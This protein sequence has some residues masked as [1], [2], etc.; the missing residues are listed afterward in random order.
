MVDVAVDHVACD[1]DAVAVVA[2]ARLFIFRGSF[3]FISVVI[4]A[5][6]VVVNAVATDD[7]VIARL[8]IFRGNCWYF[9]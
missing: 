2:V 3:P 7:V 5:V 6:A 4:S 1:V 9:F 8:F